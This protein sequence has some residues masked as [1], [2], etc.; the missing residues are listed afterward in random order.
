VLHQPK[1]EDNLPGERFIILGLTADIKGKSVGGIH[2]NNLKNLGK[3]DIQITGWNI[4]VVR[5]ECAGSRFPIFVFDKR[6]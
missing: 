4:Q 1:A 2:I 6:A 5:S 3:R